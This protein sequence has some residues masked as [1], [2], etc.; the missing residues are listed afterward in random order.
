[1]EMVYNWCCQ[2]FAQGA[3][4]DSAVGAEEV[5]CIGKMILGAVFVDASKRATAAEKERRSRF[6]FRFTTYLTRNGVDE[7]IPFPSIIVS[8]L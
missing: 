6:G 7:G 2:V 8:F 1:M 5:L 4:V 3:L